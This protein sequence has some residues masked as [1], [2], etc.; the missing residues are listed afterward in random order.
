M[1]IEEKVSQIL[2]NKT[3]VTYKKERIRLT[4]YFLSVIMDFRKRGMQASKVQKENYF[5]SRVLHA[6]KFYLT[7]KVK[8]RLSDIIFKIPLPLIFL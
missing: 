7:I 3:Q 8:Y 5:E 2:T 6:E 1:K 4:C